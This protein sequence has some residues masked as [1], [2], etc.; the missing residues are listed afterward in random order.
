MII[1]H[2]A[3]WTKNL[4]PMKDFYM[5]YFGGVPNDKYVS[6]KAHGMFMSYFLLFETGARLELMSIDNILD[7]VDGDAVV[8]LAHIAFGVADENAVDKLA[9]QMKQDGFEIVSG[10]RRTGDGYYEAC[11]LDPDG[12]RVEI[13]ALQRKETV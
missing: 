3:I 7:G 6:K 8:G 1:E 10:P 13:A 12:N 4:E 9:E 5:E 2:V 11:V